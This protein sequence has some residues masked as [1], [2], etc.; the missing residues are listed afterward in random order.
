MVQAR[1]AGPVQTHA[2][3]VA[4]GLPVA[5]AKALRGLWRRATA[6]AQC[7]GAGCTARK[8]RGLAD[9]CSA[10]GAGLPGRPAARAAVLPRPQGPRCL[11]PPVRHRL[12][13]G[14]WPE[15]PTVATALRAL[16][17]AAPGAAAAP[18]VARGAARGAPKAPPSSRRGLA[19]GERLPGCC[20]EPPVI[21][22]VLS[23]T[24]ASESLH[25]TG[26]KRRKTRGVFPHDESLVKG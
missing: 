10:W 23:T 21:R 11:G 24:K 26:R 22:R 18:A 4:L 17:G 12:P 1:Q 2:G 15:R 13:D 9:G 8:H 14:P 25:A 7:W 20:D 5:G 6:G 3:S 19:A 16:S